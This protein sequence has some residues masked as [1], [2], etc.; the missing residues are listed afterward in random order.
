[1]KYL[2][3]ITWLD[4]QSISPLTRTNFRRQFPPS[5]SAVIS[6][7]IG[8]AERWRQGQEA[9]QKLTFDQSSK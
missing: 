1:M 5:I 9:G 3:A 2:L 4:F 6:A 8:S 7:F